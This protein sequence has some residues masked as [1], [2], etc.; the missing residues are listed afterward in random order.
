MRP[1]R[2]VGRGQLAV[3][4]RRRRVRAGLERRDAAGDAA[5]RALAAVP[6]QEL[7]YTC[8]PPGSGPRLALDRDADGELDGDDNCPALAPGG[9]A[10]GD[11]DGLGAACDNC[12]A[13]PN[14]AQTDRGGWGPGSLA[15]GRGDACQCG[16][17]S[18]DGV[19]TQADVDALR[20]FLIGSGELAS[21]AKCNLVGAPGSGPGSCDLADSVALQ[22]RLA[23]ALLPLD[24]EI[25]TPD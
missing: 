17:S 10:D 23:G 19:V 21:P 25:C 18:D 6:G 2:R 20:G 1:R 16:D 11:G 15:D 4:P 14:A 9:Q 24:L 13:V 8:A 5:L 7:T 3:R 22:R 12:A